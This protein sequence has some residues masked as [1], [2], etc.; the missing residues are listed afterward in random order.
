[1][2]WACLEVRE[3]YGCVRECLKKHFKSTKEAVRIFREAEEWFRKNQGKGITLDDKNMYIYL[4][5]PK[6]FIECFRACLI[7][8]IMVASAFTQYIISLCEMLKDPHCLEVM[9]RG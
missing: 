5:L 2:V 1:M 8:G 6:G 7:D 4:R 3:V 9:E